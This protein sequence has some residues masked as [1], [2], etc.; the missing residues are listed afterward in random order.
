ME[1]MARKYWEQLQGPLK[2]LNLM[3]FSN[4][5]EFY[6]KQFVDSVAP[7]ERS[8]IFHKAINTS[9]GLVDIGTGGGFPLIPLAS[10]KKVSFS[11]YR[12]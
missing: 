7:Y 2:G 9:K 3:S 11:S 10:L 8:L 5:E 6:F 12:N 4:F 1:D